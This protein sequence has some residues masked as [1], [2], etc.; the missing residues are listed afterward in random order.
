M[1]DLS[2]I[3]KI[4]IATGHCDFRFGVNRLCQLI[5]SKGNNPYDGS[6]FVFCSKD[7]RKIKCIHFDGGGT[8][9]LEKILSEER[10]KWIKDDVM[11]IKAI[12]QKQLSWFMDGLDIEPRQFIK[13]H[14]Y[15][16]N[17]QNTKN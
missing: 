1:I 5:E 8:W 14:E 16:L 13:G 4:Y 17:R 6:L 11:N 7:K 3:E 12:S 10:F 9:L 15:E 2:S